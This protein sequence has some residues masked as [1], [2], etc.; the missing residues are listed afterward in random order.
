MEGHSFN[1]VRVRLASLRHNYSVMVNAVG[2]LVPVMAMVKADAYGHGMIRSAMAFYESGCRHFGVAELGEGIRLRQAGILGQIYVTIG[3]DAADADL[4]FIHELTPVIYDISHVEALARAAHTRGVKIGVHLKVD[5]GMSRL[6]IFPADVPLFC[7]KVK[8][9]G[10]VEVRG[11]MSHFPAADDPQAGS[12]ADAL[13]KFLP[14][15]HELQERSDVACHIANSGGV[16]NF[17]TTH[18]DMVRAGIALY[19][20]EP[21][22][23]PKANQ[24]SAELQPAMSCTTRLL[25]VKQLPAGAGVS[26]GHTYRTDKPMTIGVIPIGYEDGFNRGLS[27]RG[28]VLVGGHQAGVIGRICMNMCMIDLARAPRAKA[29]DEVVILGRQADKLITAD[30]IAAKIG[31]I[32]YEVLCQLGN[33]NERE[34]IE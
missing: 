23:I 5:T 12:T 13:T 4:F 14:V 11:V 9:F 28:E 16:L 25:Q 3:F 6:G 34:Y 2:G 10:N 32:S 26:Y 8:T 19:G 29:G 7:D 33:N 21:S 17:P 20:Y 18:C 15:C 27:N 22:G 24:L 1:R 30:D 31:T